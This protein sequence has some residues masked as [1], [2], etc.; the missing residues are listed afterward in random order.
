M[1]YRSER[2]PAPFLENETVRLPEVDDFPVMETIA[3]KVT[4]MADDASWYQE[5]RGRRQRKDGRIVGDSFFDGYRQLKRA[6]LLRVEQSSNNLVHFIQTV[7]KPFM[8]AA[9]V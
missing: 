8:L 5:K 1:D 9:P 3:D 2:N 7:G 4:Q 6:V